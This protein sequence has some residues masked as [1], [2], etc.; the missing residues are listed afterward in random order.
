[1]NEELPSP[2]DERSTEELI[3]LALANAKD[4]DESDEDYWQPVR[5]LQHRLDAALLQDIRGLAESREPMARALATDI[6][7]Q[8]VLKE[9]RRTNEVVNLLS[10]M[11]PSE[12]DS[13]VIASIAF[14]LG[15]FKDDL[16]VEHLIRLAGHS[17]KKVRYAVTHGLSEVERPDAIQT[18]IQLSADS[19]YEVRNWATFNLGSMIEHDSA[20]LRDALWLRLTEDNAEVRGEAIVGLVRRGD[21]RVMEPLRAAL[22]KSDSETEYAGSLRWNMVHGLFE[23]IERAPAPEWL[24]VLNQLHGSGLCEV[25]ELAVAIALCEKGPT[26]SPAGNATPAVTATPGNE[27]ILAKPPQQLPRKDEL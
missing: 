7:G 19:D 1:M 10:E 26:T 17:D 23:T 2:A 6:L 11:L 21:F 20:E 3:A 9:K 16:S 27:V 14:A 13:S 25:K 5:L 12:H 22:A 15:H 4:I 8:S 24:L 18:L